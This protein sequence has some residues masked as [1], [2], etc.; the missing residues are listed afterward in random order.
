MQVKVDC[1]AQ[2]I[3]QTLQGKPDAFSSLVDRTKDR[4]YT[5]LYYAMGD[6]H[7]A[8]DIVQEAYVTAFVKLESFRMESSFYTWLYR[9]AF[10][11]RASRQRQ[12]RKAASIERDLHPADLPDPTDGPA[13][14]LAGDERAVALTQALEALSVEYREIL[15]LRE[16][17]QLDYDRISS[18]LEIPLGTVRSRLFR[19]RQQLREALA[20]QEEKLF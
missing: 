9:I 4:L 10:N 14:S 5:A 17:E 6:A 13:E 3:R 16:L 20:G 8:E 12:R 7:E 2:L 1:E 18:I 19:A 15:V 11:L